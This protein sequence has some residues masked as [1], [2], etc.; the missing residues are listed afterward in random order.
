MKRHQVQALCDI[1]ALMCDTKC[2][3]P[4]T[5]TVDLTV[6]RTAHMFTTHKTVRMEFNF[7]HF[8]A[9]EVVHIKQIGLQ[10]H[11]D[12]LLEVQK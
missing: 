6:P 10:I 8:H 2:K 4:A 11:K 3:E 7:C 9:N 12:S 5:R 1:N